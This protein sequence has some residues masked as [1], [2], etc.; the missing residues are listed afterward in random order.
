MN[1]VRQVIRT[2]IGMLVTL[3]GVLQDDIPVL[4]SG[5]KQIDHIT[6]AALYEALASGIETHQFIRIGKACFGRSDPTY[7]MTLGFVKDIC[8]FIDG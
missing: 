7:D 5:R 8:I 1:I 2:R 3:N 4:G 6:V